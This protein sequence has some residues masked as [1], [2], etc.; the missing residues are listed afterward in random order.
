MPSCPAS[1]P[2]NHILDD[3]SHGDENWLHPDGGT[4]VSKPS[5]PRMLTLRPFVVAG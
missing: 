3:W 5:G 1:S 2:L 4:A